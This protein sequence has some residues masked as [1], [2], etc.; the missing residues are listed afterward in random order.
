ME[1]YK[2]GKNIEEQKVE[3]I[4]TEAVCRREIYIYK[5]CKIEELWSESRGRLYGTF[6][7]ICCV[8]SIEYTSPGGP[9]QLS[10]H[11]TW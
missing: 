9:R 5:E 7:L 2:E 11:Y 8:F 4:S 3:T 10:S 1:I 6:F